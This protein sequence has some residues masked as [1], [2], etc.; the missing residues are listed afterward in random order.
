MFTPITYALGTAYTFGRTL[1]IIMQTYYLL[2]ILN[3][4]YWSGWL[5]QTLQAFSYES[6]EH[7]FGL[8]HLLF[9]TYRKKF[10]IF[11]GLFYYSLS[12]LQM[13]DLLQQNLPCMT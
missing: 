2:L 3:L 5:K 6:F 11:L 9:Q 7:V 12:L 8:F 13:K 1:N 10:V 4:S